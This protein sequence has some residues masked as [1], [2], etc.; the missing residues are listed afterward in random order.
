MEI[1]G[2]PVALTQPATIF[3]FSI[4]SISNVR[5]SHETEKRIVLP[6]DIGSTIF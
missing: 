1:A 5:E 2:A 3:S 6:E 4:P